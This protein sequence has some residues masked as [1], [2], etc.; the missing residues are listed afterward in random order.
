MFIDLPLTHVTRHWRGTQS[1]GVDT[2]LQSELVDGEGKILIEHMLIVSRK[3][4]RGTT[5]K[6]EHVI[7][8]DPT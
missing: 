8:I 7:C 5:T 4:Q 2:S 6:Y 1:I 3:L